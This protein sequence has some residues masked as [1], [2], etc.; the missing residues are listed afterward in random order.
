[1]KKLIALILATV[2]IFALCACTGGNGISGE[3]SYDIPDG[4]QIP[5]DAVV[6]ITIAS[7]ASWPYE[8][9]WKI[10]QYIRESV[11]GT[12]NINAVPATDFATKFPLIMAA[13]DDLPDLMHFQGKP[14][15]HANYCAQGAFLAFDDYPEFLPDYEKFWENVPEDEKWMR[16]VRKSFDGK[17]YYSPSHGL[18]RSTNI[19]AWLYRKDIFDKHGLK[20]PET[21]DELYEVSKKLKEIYP[22]SYPFS[23]RSGLQNLNVIGTSWKPGF[24]F[25]EYYDFENEKWSYGATEDVMIELV[26]FFNKMVSEK[27]VPADFFTINTSSWQELVSTDRGFI[28][29]EYQ[30]RIDFFNSMARPSNPEFNLTAMKPPRAD[31]GM[32]VNMINKFNFVPSGYS[33]CNTGDSASIANAFRIINWFY[34]DEACE[35]VSWGKEGETYE[36]VD[37]KKQFIMGDE[38]ETIQTLYGVN[39]LGTHTRF[40]PDAID[41]SISEEQA[42]TTD[43]ILEHTYPNLQPNLYLEFSSEQNDKIADLKTSIETFV[44][45]NI[46]KFIIGQRPLSEWDSFREELSRLPVEELL[47]VFDEAYKSVK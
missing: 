28:M 9:D 31:N 6:D 7:H 4:K 17:I 20:A 18:E 25:N 42:A 30:V 35:L 12:L 33:V 22:D 36:V 47:S 15:G 19:R 45:E 21:M 43:F 2:M 3:I 46:Q 5:D 24:C 10:W 39:T 8:E 34:T 26:E 29:P 40:A 44:L 13:P 14:A 37:G 38:A 11:G 16:D 23:I 41:A 1:M 32:G 27:L